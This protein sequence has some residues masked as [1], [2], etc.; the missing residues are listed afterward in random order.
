MLKAAFITF[1]ICFLLQNKLIQSEFLS[2][3]QIREMTAVLHK[4][5]K[6]ES[7]VAEEIIDSSRSGQ[8]SPDPAFKC[9]IACT[10]EFVGIMDSEGNISYDHIYELLPTEHKAIVDTI[11]TKCS[12]IC[13]KFLLFF[14]DLFLKQNFVVTVGEDNCDTAWKTAKCYFEAD[15]SN[16]MLITEHLAK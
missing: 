7:G 14:C 8:L 15:M 5:C 10:M 16:M 11:T 13:K 4:H 6:A 1:L 2:N 3:D 12:G 9:Y